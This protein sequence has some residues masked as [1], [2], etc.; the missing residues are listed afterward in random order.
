M[1][2]CLQCMVQNYMFSYCSLTQH[3]C[4]NEINGYCCV[5]TFLSFKH[6]VLTLTS[7]S[8]LMYNV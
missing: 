3:F 1:T 2:V 5:R 6:Q 4:F 8:K 7:N